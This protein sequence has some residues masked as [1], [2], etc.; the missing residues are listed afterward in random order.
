MMD[1]GPASS[2]GRD[3]AERLSERDVV[4][5]RLIRDG[6]SLGEIAARTGESDLAVRETLRRL[7]AKLRALGP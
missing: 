4:V 1:E 7:A 6:A 2:G 5:L 3:D